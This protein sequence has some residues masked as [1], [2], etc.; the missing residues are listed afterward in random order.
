MCFLTTDMQ[1][2]L[3]ICNLITN[4][5]YFFEIVDILKSQLKTTGVI[6]NI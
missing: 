4:K 1:S 5:L 2:S 6:T 3:I